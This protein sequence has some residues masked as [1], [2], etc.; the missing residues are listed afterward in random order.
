M[1]TWLIVVLVVLVVLAV[2]GAV[3]RA[4]QLR[5][6]QTAFEARLLQADHDLAQAAANDRGWD[7]STLESAA[8]RIYAEQ[9]GA[10]P[11]ELQLV[12]VLDRP[13]TE[14]DF[15]VFQASGHRLTLGRQ[16]GEWVLE[17]IE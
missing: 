2:G 7:R 10:E 16:S 6:T 1:P 13:G 5:R 3:A 17:A 8:R 12:E 14:Q 11:T 4:M 9:R 15:A